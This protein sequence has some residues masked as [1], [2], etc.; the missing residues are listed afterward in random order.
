MGNLGFGSMLFLIMG[1]R[2]TFCEW[3][4]GV[5]CYEVWNLDN[6]L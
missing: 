6:G 2:L 3:G 5:V 1:V 4:F